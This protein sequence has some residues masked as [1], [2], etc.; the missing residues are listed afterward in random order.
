[1]EII[2]I[3]GL[4]TAAGLWFAGT[5]G[6]SI[7]GGF[8]DIGGIALLVCAFI[9]M[10]LSKL[11][12]TLAQRNLIYKI[13]FD[14]AHE[15]GLLNILMRLDKL[16]IAITNK[17]VLNKDKTHWIITG[18]LHN[19]QE[20]IK[21]IHEDYGYPKDCIIKEYRVKKSPSDTSFSLTVDVAVFEKTS[22]IRRRKPKIFIE[23]KRTNEK[24]GLEQLE[25]KILMD[26]TLPNIGERWKD[27]ALDLSDKNLLNDYH[28]HMKT[29]YDLGSEYW[30]GYSEMFGVGG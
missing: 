25:N 14:I 5:L 10:V 9:F 7:G 22:D 30:K 18:H 13:Y 17:E 16:D 28:T 6:I 21:I 27:L 26:T 1:M 4:T 29:L 3:Q 12:R 23:T 20:I 24:E 11:D 2:Q 19:R 8:Y 15:D